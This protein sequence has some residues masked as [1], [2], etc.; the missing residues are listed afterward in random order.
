MEGA[1]GYLW[2]I[3]TVLMPILLALAIAYASYQTWEYRKN[4]RDRPKR[5]PNELYEPEDPARVEQSVRG[6]IVWSIISFI[7]LVAVIV[8]F[9]W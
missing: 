1:S 9:F 6:I 3:S 2:A 5:V 7:L 4:S 8:I